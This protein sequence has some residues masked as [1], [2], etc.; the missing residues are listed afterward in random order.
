M[1]LPSP[2]SLFPCDDFP[3]EG[4]PR[5]DRTP[6]SNFHSFSR[7]LGRRF[8]ELPLYIHTDFNLSGGCGSD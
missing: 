6:A 4:L 7:K 2:S 8:A 1:Q 3:P 5:V